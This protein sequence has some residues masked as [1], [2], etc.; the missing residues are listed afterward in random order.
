MINNI[1]PRALR[2][3]LIRGTWTQAEARL[4][5]PPP[6]WGGHRQHRMAIAIR[7]AKL[8]LIHR[9]SYAEVQRRLMDKD[10]L[11]RKVEPQRIGQYISKGTHFFLER[12]VFREMPEIQ[13]AAPLPPVN[14]K[15]K[16]TKNG[17]KAKR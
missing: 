7:A 12:S 2:D 1:T 3:G 9:L 14:P 17:A 11:A 15:T 13:E 8:F 4:P 16:V 6:E 5:E 10:L